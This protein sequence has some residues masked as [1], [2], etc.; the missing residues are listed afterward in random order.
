[1]NKNTY[2]KKIILLFLILILFSFIG[3]S[4]ENTSKET[5]NSS[6]SDSYLQQSV[7]TSSTSTTIPCDPQVETEISYSYDVTDIKETTRNKTEL[8]ELDYEIFNF[9]KMVTYKSKEEYIFWANSDFNNIIDDIKIEGI[10][11]KSKILIITSFDTSQTIEIKNKENTEGIFMIERIFP[12]LRD[13]YYIENSNNIEKVAIKGK[14]TVNITF[15]HGVI[16]YQIGESENEAELM[17]YFIEQA[18]LVADQKDIIVNQFENI[19]FTCERAHYKI[20]PPLVETRKEIET[21]E[22][23]IIN[24]QGKDKKITFNECE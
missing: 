13:G 24:N 9:E 14:E 10:Y 12:T 5:T 8:V 17:K 23:V 22:Y 15:D 18:E 6:G 19:I 3:C 20:I 21:E 1:M 4:S 16:C 11:E 7:V 2:M